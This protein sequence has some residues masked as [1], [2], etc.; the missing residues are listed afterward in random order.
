MIV[1]APVVAAIV[2]AMLSDE[3]AT[4]L[5]PP[6]KVVMS[7]EASPRVTVPPLLKVVVPAT[8][9]VPPVIETL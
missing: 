3:G 1:L 5:T 9:L 8:E 7:P 6:T 4:A 2:P